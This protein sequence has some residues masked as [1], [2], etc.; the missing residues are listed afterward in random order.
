MYIIQKISKWIAK[1]GK[2]HNT[3][4]SFIP[5]SVSVISNI[6][7]AGEIFQTIFLNN[8]IVARRIYEMKQDIKHRLISLH[9]FKKI[10]LQID[11]TKYK[12]M[13]YTRFQNGNKQ[14]KDMFARRVKTN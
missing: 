3:G 13:S 4:E 8:S 5:H 1:I 14:I 12:N 7:N 11:D 2:A 9:Q 6:K 10:Y